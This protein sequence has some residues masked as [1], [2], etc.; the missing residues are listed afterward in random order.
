MIIHLCIL[1]R[2]TGKCP[3]HTGE[4]HRV[5]YL[6][7]GLDRFKSNIEGRTFILLYPEATGSRAGLQPEVTGQA[8]RRQREL[9]A[10]RAER[11]GC[12]L[13]LAHL[14]VIDIIQSHRIFFI[15]QHLSIIL[16]LPVRNARNINRLSRTIDGTVCKQT[17]HLLF[18]ILRRSVIDLFPQVCNRH[19]R[20]AHSAGIIHDSSF[21]IGKPEFQRT[22]F[23]G[24]IGLRRH[25]TSVRTGINH[26]LGIG[27]RMSAFGIHHNQFQVIVRQ[28]TINHPQRSDIH[29]C[30]T[31]FADFSFRYSF[32]VIDTRLRS[33][34]LKRS[35]D[36]QIIGSSFQREVFLLLQLTILCNKILHLTCPHHGSDG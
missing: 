2:S 33:L 22:F 17:Q 23:I 27:H 4:K 8:G 29:Q 16:L 28:G 31:R 25:E 19:S 3:R 24:R 35:I 30:S 6:I 5:A 36:R 32:Q 15:G 26:H 21:L 13:H 34:N 18:A 11:V 1:H 20:I 10:E 14:I 12:H 9:T 7:F